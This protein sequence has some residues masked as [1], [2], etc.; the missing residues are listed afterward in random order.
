MR[1]DKFWNKCNSGSIRADVA[2][3]IDNSPLLSH[4]KNKKYY[5]L[6]DELVAFLEKTKERIY[7]EADKEYHRQDVVCKLIEK[8]GEEFTEKIKSIPIGL[9][10]AIVDEWQDTLSDN[11]AFWDA[12]WETLDT[13]LEKVEKKYPLFFKEEK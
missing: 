4:Y 9:I 6:E 3:F 2:E 8:H 1:N 11:D 5:Q 7:R 12:V 10:D 13:V